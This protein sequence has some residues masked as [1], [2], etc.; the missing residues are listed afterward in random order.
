MIE[1]FEG[2]DG[3][4]RLIE[5]LRN[6]TIVLGSDRLASALSEVAELKEIKKNDILIEQ[7]GEDTEIYFVITGSFA[8]KVNCRQ[9][10]ERQAGTHVGEMALIDSKAVRSAT[11]VAASKSV[12]AMVSESNFSKV[13]ND[14][15]ELWRRISIELCE[16]LRNRNHTIR[17]PNE[18]PGVFI[19]SSSETLPYAKALRL[20]LDHHSS[21]IT[22]WTDQVFSPMSQTMEDLEREVNKADFGIALVMGED[23]VQS[24]N[25]QMASPRDNVVFELGL[26]MG[27]LGRERTVI[28]SPRGIDLKLPSDLLGLTPLQFT[29][30]SDLKDSRGMSSALGSVCTQLESLIDRLGPR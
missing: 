3:K 2:N 8:I 16:R 18:T 22:L 11:I 30:P 5:E 7:G 13:A 15:P 26:F 27:K 9:V 10:A 4:R 25:K 14:H 20:N 23:I 12:V 29:I 19:C 21:E 24:R 1:R 28:V 17:R 6:Q